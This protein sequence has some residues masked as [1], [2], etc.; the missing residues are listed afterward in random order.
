MGFIWRLCIANMKQRGIRTGLT[1][2]GVVIG[3]ISVVSMLALGLGV[4]NELLSEATM[5]GSVT[6]ITIFGSNEGK[7]K[8]K[9]ITDRRIVDI[10]AIPHIESVTPMLSANSFIK[11]DRYVA[12]MEITGVPRTYL[13]AMK[14]VKGS[15]P[16]VNGTRLSVLMGSGALNLFYNENTG[17]SY[18]EANAPTKEEQKEMDEED[19]NVSSDQEN[20][21]QASSYGGAKRWND[22]SGEYMEAYF[23]F[24]EEGKSIRT[25]IAGML[26]EYEYQMYC[27]MD[28][29]KKLLKR[30]AV[31]GRIE[32]QPTDEDGNTINEWV[33]SYAVVK[34]D[35][36]ENV[37]TIVKRLSDM[38]YQAESNKEFVDEVQREIKIIQILL[39]G[40]GAIA[41]VVAVIGIGNTMTTSVYDRINEIGVLKVLGCDPDEL[42]GLF[43]LE[44]G[45][46]GGIGGVIGLICSFGISKFGINK[47]GVKLLEMPK[48]TQLAVIPPWLAISSIVL[49]VVLGIFA[50]FLPAKWA[51]KMRP[52]DAVRRN[53]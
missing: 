30:N 51:S 18:A 36:V 3:V 10:E 46:L 42:M 15:V 16:E 35:D 45:I 31:D 7:R 1:I 22:L 48:N 9:M 37:D 47:L 13:E 44:S 24:D 4:K 41:L 23:G 28:T 40:I 8:D 12:Y 19:E 29:L 2:L 27:D 17:V 52:I 25:P 33:Y 49:A 11:Y 39:G 43:L 14:P 38:G 21:S 32:G 50:G 53:V 6:D 20:D 5:D 26:S 34:V